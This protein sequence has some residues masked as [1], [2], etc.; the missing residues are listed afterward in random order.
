MR[1]EAATLEPSPLTTAR[2]LFTLRTCCSLLLTQWCPG[3]L[4]TA[5]LQE[6]PGVAIKCLSKSGMRR[7]EGWEK[8]WGAEGD[9]TGVGRDHLL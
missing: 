1:R 6:K 2:G 8:L 4:G 5:L 9:H 7:S 3:H